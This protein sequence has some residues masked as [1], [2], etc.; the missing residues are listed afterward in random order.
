[1]GRPR[2]DQPRYRLRRHANGVW[3]AGW[4]EGGIS[5]RCSSGTRDERA[6][7]DFLTRLVAERA[8]RAAPGGRLTV[9]QVLDGYQSAREGVV[10]AVH[11]LRGD[12][13]VVKR[14]VGPVLVANV[15]RGLYAGL[16]AREG[17]SA[18]TIR[19]EGATLRAAFM[20]AKR[21]GWLAEPPPV[22]LPSPAPARERWLTRE[23]AARLLAAIPAE[24]THLR[25]FVVLALHTGARSGAI[26]GLSWD[27]VDFEGGR[28]DFRRPGRIETN[29]RT[30]TVP[31]T[32]T[33]YEALWHAGAEATGESVISYGDAPVGSI[34]KAFA[35]A[36]ARAQ[37]AGVTPHIL[38]HTAATWMVIGGIPPAEVARYLGTTEAMIER[39]Y[40][41]HSPD[42]L[43]R[44]AAALDR[45]FGGVG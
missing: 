37:L 29:K 45:A 12:C 14:L 2:L 38:R 5:G 24:T 13:R 7:R 18:G 34:K 1:M 44:A 3:Y 40:G 16:R 27:R 23:E 39:V 6:A 20:W 8:R 41:K 17:V 10:K 26:L 25:L 15:T 42:Y 31:L 22:D 43:R 35:R 9:T 4:T 33:L 32:A 28:V 19:R 11:A 36:C 30:T 21:E